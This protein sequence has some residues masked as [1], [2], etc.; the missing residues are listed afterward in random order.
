MADSLQAVAKTDRPREALETL[1]AMARDGGSGVV[2]LLFEAAGEYI[3][4]TDARDV[5]VFLRD[6]TFVPARSAGHSLMCELVDFY[7][8]PLSSS[9]ESRA[10]FRRAVSQFDRLVSVWVGLSRWNEIKEAIYKAQGGPL[11]HMVGVITKMIIFEFTQIEREIVSHP[12]LILDGVLLSKLGI[13]IQSLSV[14]SRT[15]AA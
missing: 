15:A 10:C 5:E 4:A 6:L 3:R 1:S 13:G 2:Y 11:Y 7:T 14:S 12:E 9:E 8:P